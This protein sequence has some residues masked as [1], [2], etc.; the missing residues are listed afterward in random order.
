LIVLPPSGKQPVQ[1]IRQ[2]L[3]QLIKVVPYNLFVIIHFEIALMA[4]L[5][6]AAAAYRAFG[7]LGFTGVIVLSH[8]T[9]DVDFKGIS[10]FFAKGIHLFI[11]IIFSWHKSPLSYHRRSY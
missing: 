9:I 8:Y 4:Y 10:A 5:T 7:F 1:I 6:I 3:V 2:V 11:L